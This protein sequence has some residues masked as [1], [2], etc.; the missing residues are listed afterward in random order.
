M[1]N[2]YKREPRQHQ[3]PRGWDNMDSVKFSNINSIQGLQHVDNSLAAAQN[4][5]YTCKNVYQDESGNLT[6]RPALRFLK[7]ASVSAIGYYKTIKG[8]IVHFVA[9]D[10]YY[11]QSDANSPVEIGAGNIAV[12]ESDTDV[13]VMYTN[14]KHKL[15]FKQWNGRTLIDIT[16]DIP[17]NSPDKPLSRLYN[18]LSRKT[19]FE[20]LANIPKNVVN[21]LF[22]QFATFEVKD[23][24]A[25]D[26][27][28]LKS[29]HVIFV[30]ATKI[31]VAIPYGNSFKVIELPVDI[32]TSSKIL[33]ED[34]LSHTACIIN[35]VS[36]EDNEYTMTQYDVRYSGDITATKWTVKLTD[37]LAYE[38]GYDNSLFIASIYNESNGYAIA[39]DWYKNGKLISRQYLGVVVNAASKEGLEAKIAISKDSALIAFAGDYTGYV[40]AY[41]LAYWQNLA[42]GKNTGKQYQFKQYAPYAKWKNLTLISGYENWYLID[43]YL[44]DIKIYTDWN[45]VTRDNAELVGSEVEVFPIVPDFMMSGPS[46]FISS[47]EGLVIYTNETYY[48]M[49]SSIQRVYDFSFSDEIKPALFNL[50]STIVIVRYSDRYEIKVRSILPQYV[51]TDRTVSDN[52][53]VLHELED[54]V[55]TSFYLDNIYWFV[56]KHRVFGTGVANEQFSIKYFDPMKYFYFEEILTGAIRVSDSSFWVFHNNGAYLIYKSVSNIYD[57]LSGGYIEVITWLC[58]STAESKGCDFENAVITLPINNYVACVTSDDISSVQ[59]REN[60]QTDDRIL[61]PMTLNIRKFVSNLLNETE[62]VITGTFRYNALFFL[63]PV[64]AQNIVPV[65]VYNAVSD[66]WWYWEL[67]V[68]RVKQVIQ[69]ETNIELLTEVNGNHII[70][71]FYTDYYEYDIGGITWNLYADRLSDLREPTQIKWYWESAILHFGTTDYKKQLLYTNFTFGEHESSTV[72]FEYNFEV[73]DREYSEHSWSEIMQVV[74][75]TKTYSNK[76]IITKFMYLQLYLKHSE[77]SDLKFEAYTR[78]KFSSISFKYRILSGGLL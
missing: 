68:N 76:N 25:L 36:V 59:M 5:T 47:S 17:L 52:F 7:Q 1:N 38:P 11:L 24:D 27:A 18:I 45:Y 23:N 19:K 69:T 12:Q 60:V 55:L 58:T 74:E 32:P 43:T 64:K 73:Y 31:S 10:K 67:P 26:Y 14:T 3:L 44:G 30:Y 34:I 40:G 39:Y 54:E 50:D 61:V 77:S 15:Q 42:D 51:T 28:I 35:T 22:S 9:D 70:Y 71:D 78:P 41:D 20:T 16:P 63:N 46:Y 2:I 21:D 66:A 75:R 6:V 8:E 29:G 33:I 62:S 65:L 53:P 4:G 57:E 37:V 49:N 56:T 72:S 48:A 13:Y